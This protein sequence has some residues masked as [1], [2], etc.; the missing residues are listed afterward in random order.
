[1]Y[2]SIK[3]KYDVK[4]VEWDIKRPVNNP[5][6]ILLDDLIKNM[7]SNEEVKM[8]CFSSFVECCEGNAP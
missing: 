7:S 8:L 2:N 3:K 4:A 5:D 1:M 6:G